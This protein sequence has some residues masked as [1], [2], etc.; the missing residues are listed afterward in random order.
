MYENL[1]SGNSNKSASNSAS[2]SPSS[3]C[4][5]IPEVEKNPPTLSACSVSTFN[6]EKSE[7]SGS[8]NYLSLPVISD[9]NSDSSVNAL[10]DSLDEVDELESTVIYKGSSHAENNDLMSF[11]SDEEIDN[12]KTMTS[13][14]S[15]MPPAFIELLKSLQSPK[16]KAQPVSSGVEVASSSAVEEPEAFSKFY[17]TRFYNF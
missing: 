1:E 5:S 16:K 7:K 15:S 14:S 13:D 8:Q 6:V 12:N 2:S 3:D 11:T 17:F 4:N 10:D 9:G